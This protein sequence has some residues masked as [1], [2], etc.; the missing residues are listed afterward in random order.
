MTSK[1]EL[2]PP[3]GLIFD[4]DNTLVDTWPTIHE[5]LRQTFEAMDVEPWTLAQTRQRVRRS[6]RESFPELFGDRWTKARDIFYEAYE[7]VHLT[8]LTPCEGA[9]EGLSA[10]AA[11]GLYLGVISNKTGRYLRS[12]AVHLGWNGY[13]GNL[14]GAG[15]AARD[16]PAPEPV[17]H[18]LDGSGL[19]PGGDVW[20]VG[21]AGVDM[22]IAHIT[23][24]VPVLVKPGEPDPEEFAQH[25]PRLHV[26]DIPEL[27]ALISRL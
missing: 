17:S 22:E 9:D 11:R 27:V 2:T 15:D 23:G 10:L 20:M 25:S 3:R 8:R 19:K 5:A 12:E 21:D 1:E 18:V 26:A 14:V 4:W 7:S 13:F 6:M 16:K 24:L